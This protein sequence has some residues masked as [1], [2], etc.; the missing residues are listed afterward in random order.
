MQKLSLLWNKIKTGLK[1]TAKFV[2]NSFWLRLLVGL[3]VAY[4]ILWFICVPFRHL[5]LQHEQLIQQYPYFLPALYNLIVLVTSIALFLALLPMLVRFLQLAFR[6]ISKGERVL[7]AFVLL[8]FIG[9][10]TAGLTLLGVWQLSSTSDFKTYLASPN[11]IP[12]TVVFT[13][14]AAPYFLQLWH[15]RQVNKLQD[16][17]HTRQQLD[18]TNQQMNSDLLLKAGEQIGHTEVATRLCG[19]QA[20]DRYARQMLIDPNN[21]NWREFQRALNIL[22]AFAHTQFNQLCENLKCNRA[23]IKHNQYPTDYEQSLSIISAL[24][25]DNRASIDQIVDEDNELYELHRNYPRRIALPL[26]DLKGCGLMC[27]NFPAVTVRSSIFIGAN[28]QNAYLYGANLSEASLINT[29]LSNSCLINATLFGSVLMNTIVN[30]AD[31]KGAK[32]FLMDA[33]DMDGS[34]AKNLTQSQISVLIGDKHTKIPSGLSRPTHWGK[35][36]EEQEKIIIKSFKEAPSI[37]QT[38]LNELVVMLENLS[39]GI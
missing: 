27:V 33:R 11:A 9:L 8:F 15:W 14:F 1:T 16:I 36:R 37:S 24:L 25:R 34:S 18:Y 4:G 6:S 22:C 26:I 32:L 21:P 20:L 7:P 38:K 31:F 2:Y 28:M 35:S 17:R 19:L 12:W 29:N 3:P 30:G 13:I 5:Y 10:F 23:D 39:Q